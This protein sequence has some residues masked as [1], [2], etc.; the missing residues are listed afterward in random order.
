MSEVVKLEFRLLLINF[1]KS[2]LS[3]IIIFGVSAYL[4]LNHW[5]LWP[6]FLIFILWLGI[7]ERAMKILKLPNNESI[8]IWGKTKEN[9]ISRVILKFFSFLIHCVFITLLTILGIRLYILLKP[10]ISTMLEN[11]IPPFE[12]LIAFIFLFVAVLLF[13]TLALAISVYGDYKKIKPNGKSIIHIF[14]FAGFEVF[15]ILLNLYIALIFHVIAIGICL[16]LAT[17]WVERLIESQQ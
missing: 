1:G 10:E 4:L 2:I 14:V 7:L 15:F 5:K 12:Q 9:G 11:Q 13:T 3:F 17:K 6:V 16:I 8:K